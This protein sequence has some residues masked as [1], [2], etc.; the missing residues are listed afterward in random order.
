MVTTLII[1]DIGERGGAIIRSESHRG[2][3][4]RCVCYGVS[5]HEFD[6][7]YVSDRVQDISL[8]LLPDS[9]PGPKFMMEI[10]FRFRKGADRGRG[11]TEP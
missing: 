4:I 1:A 10:T 8:F 7:S 11:T 9:E 3:L 6:N 5:R 2:S